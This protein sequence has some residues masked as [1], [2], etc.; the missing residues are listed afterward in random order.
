MQSPSPLPWFYRRPFFWWA[1]AA[2]CAILAA[3]C[4]RLPLGGWMAVVLAGLLLCLWSGELGFILI[5]AAIFGS[6]T[7][8]SLVPP[9]GA[10]Q[11]DG[12]PITLRGVL[13]GPG[14]G[15]SF[16]LQAEWRLTQRGWEPERGRFGLAA[17][18]GARAGDGAEV[19]GKVE[20]PLPATHPGGPSEELLWLRRG[21]RVVIRLRPMGYVPLGHRPLP[22]WRE[23][24]LRVRERALALNR[25]TLSPRA[26]LIANDFLIGDPDPPDPALA[27]E[28]A[29]AFRAS[30]TIHL[31]VVSGT[32][33]TLV[34]GLFIWLGWRF[35][36]ARRAFWLVGCVALAGYYFLTDGSPPVARAA[37]MGVTVMGALAFQR[38]P[39]G[40]NCLGI[41]ALALLAA[42][43]FTL[44]D[45]GFQL[46]VAAL[47]A[48]IR[49]APPLYEALAPPPAE[50]KPVR[51]PWL[52]AFH[53]AGAGLIAT[54]TA[55]HLG[56]AP[57]LAFH[58]QQSGWGS[59]LAN[60]PMLFT[61]GRLMSLATAHAV[62]G[63]V[64]L[65]FLAPLVEAHAR[66]LYG[67]ASFFS[68]PPLGATGVF[69]PPA[70]LLPL[71]LLGIAAPSALRL[72]RAGTLAVAALLAGT[73]L[74]SDRLP[75]SPPRDAT[76]YALDVGQGDSLLL[77]G[78][79]GSRVLVD[80]GPSGKEYGLSP[81]VR[82]L[83]ALRVARLDAVVVSHPHA[84][85]IGGL[86]DVLRAFPVGLLIHDVE[87]EGP[88]EWRAV[89]DLAARLRVPTL[90]P[91]PGDRIAVRRSRLTVLGPLESARPTGGENLNERSLVLRWDGDGASFLLPGDAETGEEQSLLPWG[92]GLHADV[93]KVGHHGS[94]G[95]TGAEWLRQVS[96]RCAVISCG[97][98]NRFGH[99]GK[100]TLERLRS[101]GIPTARTDLGGMI[102]VRVRGGVV[103][104]TRFLAPE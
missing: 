61:A 70:W 26:A 95:S 31:L 41:A 49:L 28:V 8:L 60:L 20:R 74:L 54:S 33:V 30:G 101:A 71:C 11:E 5:V 57:L 36:A 21:A 7:A 100:E 9:P 43:P 90:Q 50:A 24:S 75:S 98:D 73:L 102:T 3:Y 62:L 86:P 48:L 2:G 23:W 1:L 58:F 38:E 63:S 81:V 39:D 44:F 22:R 53:Q 13:A 16:V 51:R 91:R 84:D 56:V 80:A 97:R 103:E 76:L 14:S 88:E 93:L 35:Y 29:D 77:R 18:P 46:S 27:S 40:E 67:W 10:D 12:A 83:R 66:E 72:G 59:I 17:P 4:W 32:Q 45:P 94:S 52:H 15:K 96:P 92:P 19:S 89:R 87:G 99:P 37:V 65:P 78:P 6:L 79:D 68:R 25:R 64:G 85:H 42:Q 47:W 69:P 34:L 104:V 55:A 82:T